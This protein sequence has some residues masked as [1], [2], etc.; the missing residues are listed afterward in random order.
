MRFYCVGGAGHAYVE[1]K[2][3]SGNHVAGVTQS[4]V[5]VLRIEPAALDSFVEDLRRVEG[6]KMGYA[7][8]RAI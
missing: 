7:R 5:L 3:E 8:L 6:E 4:T 2:M 1:L